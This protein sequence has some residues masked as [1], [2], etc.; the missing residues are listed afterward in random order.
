MSGG[1]VTGTNITIG[2]MSSGEITGTGTISVT[3]AMSG[4]S[5]TGTN[6]T[7]GSMSDGEITGTGTITISSASGGHISGTSIS[8]N[9]YLLRIV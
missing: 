1:S 3:G 2:S 7:I 8:L 9:G 6:I 5:V 4:G